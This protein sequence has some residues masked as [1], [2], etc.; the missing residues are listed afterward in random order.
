MDV[1]KYKVRNNS[2]DTCVC[3]GVCVHIN[4]PSSCESKLTQMLG[5]KA[6]THTGQILTVDLKTKY[7]SRF[8]TTFGHQLGTR[9]R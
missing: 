5:M 7:A 3:V 6:K 8:C 9:H 4:L 2:T 1:G